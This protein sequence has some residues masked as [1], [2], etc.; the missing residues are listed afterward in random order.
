M[1]FEEH[2]KKI[3]ESKQVNDFYFTKYVL[4]VDKSILTIAMSSAVIIYL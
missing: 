1:H 2:L 3:K 4:T